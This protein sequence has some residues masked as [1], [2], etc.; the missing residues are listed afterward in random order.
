M[1]IVRVLFFLML[2]LSGGTML[3]L[4]KA[5]PLQRRAHALYKGGRSY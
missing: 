2:L 3:Q 4:A 1:A 5:T